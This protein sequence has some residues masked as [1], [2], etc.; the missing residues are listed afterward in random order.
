MR[1][2]IDPTAQYASLLRPTGPEDEPPKESSS[3][4][5]WLLEWPQQSLALALCEVVEVVDAPQIHVLP[6]G[7]SW[8][9]AVLSWREQF[10][11]LAQHAT[12]LNSR[13]VVT[14]YQL[15]PGEPLQYAAFAIDG[16]PRQITVNDNLDCE[17]PPGCV[18]AEEQLR[19]SFRFEDRTVVV[20][21]LSA[22]FS[23]AGA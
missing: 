1:R 23:S 20:P 13:I 19:A 16:M 5:A 21:E 10:L 2:M 6:F 18:F 3:G 17:L 14:A 22:L 11:P 8:C 7:P 12:I 4:R 15:E 9:H